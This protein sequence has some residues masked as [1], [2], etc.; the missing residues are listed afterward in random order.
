M[1]KADIY[2][3]YKAAPNAQIV[4]VHMEAVNHWG[5]SRE[6]LHSFIQDKGMFSRVEVP[7]DGEEYIF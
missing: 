3:V 5:L 4:V 6:D 1:G 2:E 7:E